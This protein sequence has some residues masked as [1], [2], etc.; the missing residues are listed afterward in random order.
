MKT[1]GLLGGMSWE[2][3][4]TYYQQIN[5]LVSQRLGGAH[6]AKLL[7][8][9]VDFDEIEKCQAA[10]DWAKSAEILGQAAHGLALAGADFI[11]IGANTMHKVFDEIQAYTDVPLLHIADATIARLKQHHITQ[12]GLLGTKYTLQEDFYK[13]RLIQAGINVLIPD[14]AGVDDVNRIIFQEL[15]L[16]QKRPASKAALLQQIA[17]LQAR[18][19]QGII[20]GCTELD[21]LVQPADVAIPVF[22]TTLIHSQAAVDRALS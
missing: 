22:D 12:V 13:Q 14:A 3:T 15:V 7:I 1:I 6:S 11:L 16:S 4:V 17:Q 2:S 8:A 18:G 10:N 19:A 21:L 20:L 5:T 9:S